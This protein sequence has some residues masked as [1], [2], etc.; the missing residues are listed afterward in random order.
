[1]KKMR[2]MIAVIG[3]MVLSVTCFAACGGGGGSDSGEAAG[4]EVYEL[5][6]GTIVNEDHTLTLSAERYAAAVEEATDGKVK[7]TVYPSSQLGDYLNVYDELSMGSID[8]AWQTIP[9]TYDKRN[10]L[11]MTPYLVTD[12][13]G[14]RELYGNKDSFFFKTLSEVNAE[15]GVTL[16]GIAPNGFMGVGAESVGDIDTVFDFSKEQ[17]ALIR[18]ASIDTLIAQVETMGYRVTTIAYADLY[19]SLQTGVADGWYG[20]SA[21]SNIQGFKDVISYFIDYRSVNEPMGMLMSTQTLE[22]LPQEYQDIMIQLAEEENQIVIGDV[23]TADAQAIKDLEEY[24]V[25]IIAPTDEQLAEMSKIMRE[26]VY[27][28][29]A[30]DFGEELMNEIN[31]WVEGQ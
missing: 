15:K 1:M 29:F 2:K 17:D 6:L 4:D 24:G 10:N 23:E 26:E 31:A 18:S 21:I 3:V 27:P 25:E 28:L 11:G 9:D 19:S 14:I 5:R 8:M 30:D 20:G 16:L 7:I 22:S 12:Y 13:D